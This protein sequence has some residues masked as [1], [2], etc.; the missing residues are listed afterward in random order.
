MHIFNA[1]VMSIYELQSQFFGPVHYACIRNAVYYSIGTN[2]DSHTLHS[3][4]CMPPSLAL[5]NKLTITVMSCQY[6]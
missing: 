5:C 3:M 2:Y 1:I 4:L 6:S